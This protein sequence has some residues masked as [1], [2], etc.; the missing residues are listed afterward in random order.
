VVLLVPGPDRLTLTAAPGTGSTS[1][2]GWAL[3]LPG[4]GP[5]PPA[6][7]LDDRGEVLVDAKH[8]TL[9][10]LTAHGLEPAGGWGMAVTSTRDPFD[11]HHAEWWRTRTRWAAAQADPTSWVHRTP[12]MA[13]RIARAV[14]LPFDGWVRAELGPRA[15]AGEAVHLNPGH[16]AE[17]D[18]VVRIESVRADLAAAVPALADRVGAIPH[19]NR[20]GDRPALAAAYTPVAR[21]IV[22][23]LHAPDLDR[24]GY[25]PP[26]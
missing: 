4:A 21:D 1:L 18:V 23:R 16:V 8:A 12:G 13:G 15:E 7:L 24:F 22:A 10:H 6:D 5:V 3:G 17:A 26:V 19:L 20:T 25:A 14:A 2:R 11:H 9:A